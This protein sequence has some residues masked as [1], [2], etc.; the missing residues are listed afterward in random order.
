MPVRDLHASYLCN[1]IVPLQ[2]VP[3]SQVFCP[4]EIRTILINS[5]LRSGWFQFTCCYWIL[6]Y[7]LPTDLTVAA[8]RQD[9]GQSEESTA[10]EPINQQIHRMFLLRVKLMHFVNSL[11]NYIMTRV[12]LTHGKYAL[13]IC[14]RV[15]KIL[16]NLF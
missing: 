13:F 2:L 16:I 7:S 4:C 15:L 9:G 3:R 12:S 14:S 6:K 8:K 10:K 11:H 5:I 1:F